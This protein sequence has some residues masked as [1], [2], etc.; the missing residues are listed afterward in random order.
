MSGIGGQYLH[1]SDL[2]L[3]F[4]TLQQLPARYL[5]ITAAEIQHAFGVW[6]RPAD[7]AQV[8]KGP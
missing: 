6:V 1:L 8:V 5:A 4:D 2:G 7:L 3:P